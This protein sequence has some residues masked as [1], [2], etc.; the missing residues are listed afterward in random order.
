MAMRGG[1]LWRSLGAV[2]CGFFGAVAT[3]A[4]SDSIHLV[5][6]GAGTGEHS[7]VV[8]GFASSSNGTSA[9]GQ[10]IGIRSTPYEDQVN[11]DL[12]DNGGGK[13]RMPRRL[14]PPIHGGSDGWFDIKNIHKSDL[15]ITASVGVN[16]VNQP[17][18]RL[19]R[20]SGRI[21]INGKNG[22]YAGECQP[23]DPATVQRKF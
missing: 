5:C 19:D 22:D 15:E 23:Y 4:L 2:T 14:L 12:D 18:L 9:W 1:N 10:A 11:I 8:S 3:P 16:F 13:I 6:L 21:S 7:S 17:K 20:V